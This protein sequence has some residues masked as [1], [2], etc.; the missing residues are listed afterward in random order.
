MGRVI[1]SLKQGVP[2][3][4]KMDLSPTKTLKKTA[5][6]MLQVCQLGV[7]SSTVGMAVLADPTNLLTVTTLIYA[8]GAGIVTAANTR[9]A[10]NRSSLKDLKCTH[11][12]YGVLLGSPCPKGKKISL[13]DQILKSS[14][15]CI[16]MKLDM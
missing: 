9:L 10:P 6:I 4:P 8:I 7:N 14:H 1:Q 3:A 12:K 5:T 13:K 2:V 16:C 15:I 11:S